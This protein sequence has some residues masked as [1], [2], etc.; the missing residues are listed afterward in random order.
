MTRTVR[1]PVS[2]RVNFVVAAGALLAVCS[3][4]AAAG[5]QVSLSPNEQATVRVFTCRSLAMQRV[6]HQGEEVVVAV[7]EVGHGS[8]LIVTSDGIILTAR[9]VIQDASGIA[10][11]LPM[12]KQAVPAV[13]V[14]EDPDLD[15]AFLKV[16]GDFP[17]H[18]PIPSEGAIKTLATRDRLFS[19]GYPLDP[20]A[21]TPT[22]QEGIVSRLTEEGLLQTSAALNPGHSGGPAFVE[23]GGRTHLIGIAI[24]RHRV[25]EGM[26]LILPIRSIVLAWNSRAV[27]TDL[28][29]RVMERYQQNPRLWQA[30]E[31]YSL[32]VAEMTEAFANRDNPSY[33]F[34]M[35]G[36]G[37]RGA[38]AFLQGLSTL[39]VTDMLPEAQL[40]VSGYLWNVFVATRNDEALRY[41]VEIVMH[42]RNNNPEVFA[43]SLFAQS[44]AR[45]V[46]RMPTGPGAAGPGGLGMYGQGYVPGPEIQPPGYG[47]AACGIEGGSCCGGY[48]TEGLAC[49]YGRCVVPQECS[50]DEPCPEGQACAGGTCT[51][52]PRIPL[53]RMLLAGGLVVDDHPDAPW[54]DGGAGTVGGLFQVLRLGT[55]T[56]W[57]FSLVVGAEMSMGG[58]RGLFAFTALTDIGVRLLLGSPR[59]AA[60]M[61]LYYNL[62]VTVAEGRTSFAYLAYRAMAGVQFRTF[63]V[64]L[65]WSETGRS[66]D[67]TFRAAE[68]YLSWGI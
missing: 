45:V 31:R 65:S 26:G 7:P 11:K 35:P 13:V 21:S 68:L 33:W 14:Y 59:V 3:L 34:N 8:G 63:E 38:P 29:P 16:R 36:A 57:M 23:V 52:R 60:S 41:C 19:I 47:V 28:A 20:S 32:L 5:A 43:A 9:H 64:G 56:P 30:L 22:T 42:L 27:Q 15:F 53:F 66:A 48:C 6:V 12:A 39:A 49:I 40:L 18:I 55:R 51:E 10:V 54:V 61:A 62:G 58:W 17:A 25:G 46:E 4:P 44:L 37:G 67:S 1:T 50:Q 24:A 2:G